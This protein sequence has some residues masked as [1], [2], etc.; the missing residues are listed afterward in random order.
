M[1]LKSES[2]KKIIDNFNKNVLGKYPDKSK[3]KSSHEGNLGHWLEFN[4]GGKI[5]SDGD[6]DL[7]GFE[8]KIESKKCL[9]VTGALLTEYFVI[10]HTKHLIRK[11][12]MKICGSL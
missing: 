3:L 6:A 11:L 12:P 9:G 1:L 4:L 8:C 10:N 7:N 2:R 5:D